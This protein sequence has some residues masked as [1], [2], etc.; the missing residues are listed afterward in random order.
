MCACLSNDFFSRTRACYS[1]YYIFTML[2]RS[3]SLFVFARRNST[4]CTPLSSG[5]DRVLSS[6]D[7]AE[8]L[9]TLL[10]RSAFSANT[11]VSSSEGGGAA[12]SSSAPTGAS[13]A[14]P[15]TAP[16]APPASPMV[17][18]SRAWMSPANLTP[19]QVVD[20]LGAH[21]IGQEPAKRAIAVALRNRWR[22]MQLP[23]T[24]QDEIIPKNILMVRDLGPSVRDDDSTHTTFLPPPSRPSPTPG[25]PNWL[26]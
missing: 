5:V 22:R 19:S 3:A 6:S 2:R 1:D 8:A 23:Q 21:I 25:W 18:K 15:S 26:R 9:A 14:A 10:D 11:G 7:V 24:Q 17:D 20:A 13:T 12:N 4:L 16:G